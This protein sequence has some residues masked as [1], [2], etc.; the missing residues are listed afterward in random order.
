MVLKYNKI[1]NTKVQNTIVGWWIGL[2]LLFLLDMTLALQAIASYLCF[3][4]CSQVFGCDRALV[5]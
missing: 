2:P 4:L 3:D 1:Q 5:L